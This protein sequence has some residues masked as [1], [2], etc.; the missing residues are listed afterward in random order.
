[1][2]VSFS[3]PV[4]LVSALCCMVAAMLCMPVSGSAASY[5]HEYI[6]EKVRRGEL[7]EFCMYAGTG[8]KDKTP[9]GRRYLETYGQDWIHMHH[10]CWALAD[11]QNGN[12]KHAIGNLNYVLRGIG[13]NSKLRPLVLSQKAT[14]HVAN[15]QYAEAVPLYYNIIELTPF[16][17]DGY[18][19]LAHVFM[20]QEDKKTAREII[21]L[22]LQNIPDSEN[23]KKLMEPLE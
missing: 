14:I 20:Q 2:T 5:A 18:V 16:S 9:I 23:L 21:Q 22:G 3:K 4:V 12:D 13:S 10:Y 1:M 17:E 19:G 11:S 15:R 6:D 8:R 7:P